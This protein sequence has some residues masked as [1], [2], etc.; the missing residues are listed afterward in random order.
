MLSWHYTEIN[1][2][3]VLETLN[4]IFFPIGAGVTHYIKY[5][6]SY[7]YGFDYGN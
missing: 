2:H 1:S 4:L 7:L 5:V 3:I 6:R